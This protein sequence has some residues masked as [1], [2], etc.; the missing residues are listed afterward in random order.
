MASEYAAYGFG[1]DS[2]NALQGDQ[3]ASDLLAVPQAEGATAGIGPFTR[4][5]Y[6]MQCHLRGK[7]EEVAPVGRRPVI[8]EGVA[9]G[10]V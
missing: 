4:Y 10:S 2:R 1:A 6:R 7:K 9:L 3:L 8:R 5:L